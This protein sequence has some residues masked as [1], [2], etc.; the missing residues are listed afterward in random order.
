[1]MGQLLTDMSAAT[2]KSDPDDERIRS[3]TGREREVVV[4]VGE[5]LKSKD[6]AD[7]LFISPTT[8][9]H[10]LTSI[11][12]KLEV[13]DRVELMLFAYR[14]GLAEAPKAKK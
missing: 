10:H 11:F 2:S 14:N 9:R 5:G 6:V 13:S 12:A 1:M 8:V 7:R 4:L 3:L